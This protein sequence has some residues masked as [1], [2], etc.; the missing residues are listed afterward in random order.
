MAFSLH[1]ASTI[2]GVT[3]EGTVVEVAS[4]GEEQWYMV[5]VASHEEE[6]WWKWHHMGRDELGG[7]E[8][9]TK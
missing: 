7:V 1:S 4:H 3:W 2:C 5:E 6:Q 8:S 9:H